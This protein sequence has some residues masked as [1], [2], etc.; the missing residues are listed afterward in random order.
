MATLQ[1]LQATIAELQ[2]K[3]SEDVAQVALLVT[4]VND[5][6]TRINNGPAAID[7]AAEVAAIQAAMGTLGSDNPAIQAAIDA[8]VPPTPQP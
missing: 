7:Y 4:K 3:V 2:T 5:L 1:E 8:A 6:I